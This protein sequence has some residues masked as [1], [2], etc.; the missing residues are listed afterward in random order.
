[1]ARLEGA[2]EQIDRRLESIERGI[3]DLRQEIRELRTYIDTKIEEVRSEMYS[4]FDALDRKIDDLRR[5]LIYMAIGFITAF[6]GLIA[7]IL[8][9]ILKP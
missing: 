9:I 1:M 6:A 5:M 3:V 4:R 8:L 2:Y 7:T